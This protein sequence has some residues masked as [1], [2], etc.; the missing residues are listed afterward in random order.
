MRFRDSLLLLPRLEFRVQQKNPKSLREA[1]NFAIEAEREVAR[2]KRLY[3][4]VDSLPS[5]SRQNSDNF[6]VRE[7]AQKKNLSRFLR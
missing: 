3:D 5:T 6:V 1:I 2:R 4:E 7:P